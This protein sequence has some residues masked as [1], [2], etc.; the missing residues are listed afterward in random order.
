MNMSRCLIPLIFVLS[1]LLP[2]GCKK[3]NGPQ[4]NNFTEEFEYL[5]EQYVRMGAAIGIIDKHQDEREYFFG[6]LS[7][8][9]GNPPDRQT[10]FEVGSIT[11]TFT[12]TLLAK[13]ILDGKI[14]LGDALPVR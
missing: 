8:F 4:F 2:A 7:K 6:T 1:L 12:A 13:M 3:D 11:K 9:N 5:V 10:I 14:S